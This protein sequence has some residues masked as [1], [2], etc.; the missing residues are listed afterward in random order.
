MHDA[1]GWVGIYQAKHMSA[2]VITN[3]YLAHS[4]HSKNTPKSDINYSASV[5]V[6]VGWYY[7]IAMMSTVVVVLIMDL[8]YHLYCHIVLRQKLALKDKAVVSI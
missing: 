1:Q 3:I 5:I 8:E 2:C 6:I 4:L 7:S